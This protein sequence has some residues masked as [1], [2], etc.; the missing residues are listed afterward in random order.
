[1]ERNWDR[2]IEEIVEELGHSEGNLRAWLAN[3]PVDYREGL[4]LALCG[5]TNGNF[6]AQVDAIV[7]A[8]M[9]RL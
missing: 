2:E 3:Q 9:A 5:N 8:I 7:A 1:M 6:F 4:H